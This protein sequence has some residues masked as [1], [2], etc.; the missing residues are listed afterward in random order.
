VCL[1]C[2]HPVFAQDWEPFLEV[3]SASVERLLVDTT[4]NELIIG[5]TFIYLNNTEVNGIAN[6]THD[7]QVI[8]L[9]T[10]LDNC[11]NRCYPVRTIAVYKD[12]YYC[13]WLNETV[14]GGTVVNKIARWDGLTWNA[15][16][17]GFD[18]G[19]SFNGSFVKDDTLIVIGGFGVITESDTAWGIAKWD[20]GNWHSLNFPNPNPPV[21]AQCGAYYKGKIY[22][23]GG[24]F[25]PVGNSYI[26]DIAQYDGVQ[27]SPVGQGIFGGAWHGINDMV[28]YKDKLYVAGLFRK[29][30][31][32][33]G[34]KIMTWDGENW[35]EVGGG[36][37]DDFATIHQ[38]LVHDDKLYVMGIFNCAGTGLPV[39]N[40][41][42]WDGSR[43]CSC[44]RSVFDNRVFDMVFWG[45]TLL[46]GGGF[47]K[48]NDQNMVR[49]VRWVGDHSKDT[50]TTA[51]S[52]IPVIYKGQ[53]PI[54]INPQPSKGLIS[55]KHP[56]WTHHGWQVITSTGQIIKS[57]G[58]PGEEETDINLTDLV[59]GVYFLQLKLPDRLWMGKILVSQ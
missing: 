17:N 25:F 3:S 52:D 50:C 16:Q 6:V 58:S 19:G 43:W 35:G 8:K 33:L 54:T 53:G 45:D 46:V 38:M 29:I 57:S 49:L 7:G 37:C 18:Y 48:V 24:F 39:S 44:G 26:L 1:S 23:G 41:A 13:G 21:L 14:N 12:N 27:W 2:T 22:L 55:V 28:V 10:G 15:L 11:I 30:D 20:G 51:I 47:T 34:N 40:I 42:V 32:N 36:L 9:G 59:S 5:G 4:S 31:G 56:G